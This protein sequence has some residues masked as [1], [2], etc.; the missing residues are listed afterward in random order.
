MF[1]N[2]FSLS[3]KTLIV[4]VVFLFFCIRR[5]KVQFIRNEGAAGLVRLSSD[6]DLVIL[7]RWVSCEV[8]DLAEHF[9]SVQ[10]ITALLSDSP[11]CLK[12]KWCRTCPPTPYCIL[13]TV[14]LHGVLRFLPHR[15]RPVS[16]FVNRALPKKTFSATWFSDWIIAW[17]IALRLSRVN[18]QKSSP[19]WWVKLVNV[20]SE[21][22][23]PSSLTYTFSQN[24]NDL[25]IIEKAELMFS[26]PTPSAPYGL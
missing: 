19:P 23:F 15:T 13:A 18:S 4:N 14:S 11:A 10:G 12:R 8:S 3:R 6:A 2:A 16:V 20:S 22:R 5:E 9:L 24:I 17:Q 7:L 1:S 25:E 21:D 26:Q